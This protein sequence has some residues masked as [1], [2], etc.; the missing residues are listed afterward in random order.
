MFDGE[1]IRDDTNFNFII[2]YII[3]RI[4]YILIFISF[5]FFIFLFTLL[6]QYIYLYWF[7]YPIYLKFIRALYK[8]SFA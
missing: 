2:F 3:F 5:H 8:E 1:S 6:V 7:L 4:R